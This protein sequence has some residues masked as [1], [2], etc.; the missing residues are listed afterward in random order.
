MTGAELQH[1]L[2]QRSPRY[3]VSG[4][5]FNDLHRIIRDVSTWE[6]WLVLVGRYA[7]ERLAL[8]DQA[9]EQGNMITA[10]EHFTGAAIYFHFSQ[11]G[12]FDDEKRKRETARRS[13]EAHRCAFDLL[14]PPVTQLRLPFREA[15]LVA[16]VR[17]PAV[18]GGAPAVILLPGVDS[19]KEEMI[20]FESVFHRRSLGTVA[21]EGPGQG[22]SGET[23]PLVEDYEEAVR[24]LLDALTEVPGLRTDRIG[25]YGRSMGGYLAPR[26]AALELRIK[27][28]ASAGGPFDL[29]G[30][31]GY[32]EQLKQFFCHAWGVSSLEEGRERASRVT[33]KD[34]VP[35]IQCPFLVLHGD[36]DRIFS[37]D[38]GRRMAA[39]ATCDTTLV[40][41]PEGDHVNDNIPY[42]YRPLVA[43]WFAEK[44]S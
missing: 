42:K 16:N 12:Y 29:R 38:E 25:L 32:S 13:R 11:L 4:M 36:A 44:L 40:I 21:F 34:L 19:T 33:L 20:T 17:L 9:L 18:A 5:D 24:V 1:N 6:E 35:R 23:L 28:V 30:W 26:S 22:E 8:A 27:A 10:A 7:S 39:A 2:V 43:D 41:Y 37:G 15:E 31:D 3:V 14:E